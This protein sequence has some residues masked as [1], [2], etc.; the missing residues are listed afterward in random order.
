MCI[1]HVFTIIAD[2][3][4]VLLM[5][6]GGFISWCAFLR[7]TRYIRLASTH[8]M[9]GYYANLNSSKQYF[10]AYSH[11]DG[12]PIYMPGNASWNYNRRR[13]GHRRWKVR[14]RAI[15]PF[16]GCAI[17]VPLY[18]LARL[19]TDLCIRLFS[20]SQRNKSIRIM[21]CVYKRSD[22]DTHGV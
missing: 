3:A 5:V 12:A 2:S 6:S 14:T 8:H 13:H 22:R 20:H 15:S 7:F 19:G 9:L 11:F 1:I 18:T 10:S 4:Y 17:A 21:P 16:A